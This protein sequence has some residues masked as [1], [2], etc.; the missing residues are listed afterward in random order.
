MENE[1]DIVDFIDYLKEKDGDRFKADSDVASYL[2]IT[3]AQ[4]SQWRTARKNLTNLQIHRLFEKSRR[5]A[6]HDIRQSAIQPIVEFFPINCTESPRGKNWELFPTRDGASRHVRGLHQKLCASKGVYLFYDTR[7]QALY[8][9][10]TTRQ[11]LWAEMT[12]ALNRRR[13]KQ[14]IKLVQHP[15]RNQEFVSAVD[16]PRRIENTAVLLADVASYFSAYEIELGMIAAL[17]A[18]LI[19]AFPNDL[20][21]TKMETF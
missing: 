14:K 9:G 16:Q 5:A 13:G 12:S 17:E 1:M 18:F 15:T 6:E 19:R 4:L 10:R 3:Q 21:N 2:N 11:N 7:G 8:A 20:L